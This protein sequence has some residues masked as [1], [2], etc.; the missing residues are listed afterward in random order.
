LNLAAR[1]LIDDADRMQCL[2][3]D[4]PNLLEASRPPD[5]ELVDLI[6]QA[7]LDRVISG[8]TQELA[9]LWLEVNHPWVQ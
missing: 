8:E 6:E 1:A 7:F 5:P 4:L 3:C 9:Y 2:K